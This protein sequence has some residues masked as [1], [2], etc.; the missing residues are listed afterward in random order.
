MHNFNVCIHN[1]CS[2][3]DGER[4]L[5][6]QFVLSWL[7]LGKRYYRSEFILLEKPLLKEATLYDV[8]GHNSMGVMHIKTHKPLTVFL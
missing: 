5:C 4:N 1:G 7:I 3:Q 2:T 6:C 8:H